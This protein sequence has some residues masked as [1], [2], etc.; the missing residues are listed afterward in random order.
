MTNN[1]SYAKK[2]KIFQSTLSVHTEFTHPPFHYQVP[3]VVCK[4]KAIDGTL[5]QFAID[6][7]KSAQ[8]QISDCRTNC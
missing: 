1:R 2:P 3:R 5:I 7:S 4:L 6:R 8:N